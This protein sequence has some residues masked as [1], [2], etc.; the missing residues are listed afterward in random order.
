MRTP[1]PRTPTP[2]LLVPTAALL[3]PQIPQP[4]IPQ[5]PN[6]TPSRPSLTTHFLVPAAASVAP[7]MR[8]QVVVAIPRQQLLQ[9]Q[10]RLL[11][12]PGQLISLL[13]LR[14]GRGGQRDTGWQAGW[15]AVNRLDGSWKE[16][17][18]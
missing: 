17:C 7:A 15:Q 3:A 18:D 5:P 13:T 12:Q 6:L 14:G 10:L 16:S 4:S 1:V 8:R 11:V 9:R 2:H